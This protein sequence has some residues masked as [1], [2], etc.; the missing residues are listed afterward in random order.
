MKFDVISLFPETVQNYCSYGIVGRALKENKIQL[1]G[2]QLRDYGIGKYQKVDDAPFGGGVGMV[3][4]PEPLFAAHRN[5]PKLNKSKTLLLTPRGETLNQKFIR[6][7]LLPEEQLIIFCGRYEGFDE[8][9]MKLVDYPVSL[10]NYVLTGGEVGAMIIIDA[11]TRLLPGVLPKGDEAHGNDS[12]ADPEA[13]NYEAPQYTR[14]EEFEGL[15]VPDV[16]ISGN[17]AEI[18]KWRKSFADKRIADC[19]FD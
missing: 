14:P 13:Q 18:E 7:T 17:H 15:R 11:V 5:V 6:E 1:Q 19:S 3:L 8:R 16:L 10:G 4:K 2:H 9:V 12:F